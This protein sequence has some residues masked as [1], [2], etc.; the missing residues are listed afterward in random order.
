MGAVGRGEI[1]R[2]CIRASASRPNLI[3][4][5]LGFVRVAA[6]VDDDAGAGGG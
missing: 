2:D 4:H 6:I 3:D 1:G 5:S